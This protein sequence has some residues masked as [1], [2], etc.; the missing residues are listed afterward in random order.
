MKKIFFIVLLIHSLTVFSQKI[1]L[2]DNII[3]IDGTAVYSY[4]KITNGTEFVVYELNTKNELVSCVYFP[5]KDYRKITF[6]NQKKSLE[7][8]TTYW[9]K[10]LI[11]WLLEQNVLTLTGKLNEEKI[12]LL[13]VKFDQKI[14][15]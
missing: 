6:S 10:S 12:D 11:K 2:K 15:N 3:R 4:D 8:T 13:I 9:N 7:T 14:T 1:E 5:F